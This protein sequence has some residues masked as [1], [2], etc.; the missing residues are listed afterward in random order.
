MFLAEIVRVEQQLQKDHTI[1][2]GGISFETKVVAV[3]VVVYAGQGQEARCG[4]GWM[5]KKKKKGEEGEA[6]LAE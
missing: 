6:V 1:A 4:R 5:K 2:K 3:A